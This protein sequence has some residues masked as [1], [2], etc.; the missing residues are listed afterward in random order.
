MFQLVELEGRNKE[1]EGR[2]RELLKER[3]KFL[4]ELE[5]AK[6]ELV[7]AKTKAEAEKPKK[8]AKKGKKDAKKKL[9]DKGVT[10][11]EPTEV[12][13]TLEEK[14]VERQQSCEVLRDENAV[15]GQHLFSEI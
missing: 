3:D 2:T 15:S 12:P 4:K 11:P 9:S 8:D 6:K 7:Q 10:S 1:L 5:K 14:R 13:K